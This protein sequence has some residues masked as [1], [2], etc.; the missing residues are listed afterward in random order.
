MTRIETKNMR[1]HIVALIYCFKIVRGTELGQEVLRGPQ[2][3][4]SDIIAPS[5]SYNGLNQHPPM[6]WNNWNAFGC[7]VSE[8]M[9]ISTAQTIA[10][11]GLR[12]LGYEYIMMDDC[13]S[14]GRNLTG[15]L[16]P[17]PERFPNGIRHL[18][19]RL[20]AM[21]FKF[22]M[23]SSA[24]TLTCALYAGSLGFETEDAAFFAENH[25]DYLKYDNCYNNG[26]QGTPELSFNRYDTMS[27]ALLATGRPIVYALCQW[28]TDYVWQWSQ[29]ISNSA[30]MSGDIYDS[31]NRPDPGC[32]TPDDAPSALALYKCSVMSILNTMATVQSMSRSG[33]FNDMDMLEVGNGGMDDNEYVTHFSMWAMLSSPLLIS[34]DIVS[35]S[36]ADLSILSNP[37]V[38]ALSQDPSPRAGSRIWKNE[39]QDKDQFGLCDHQLWTRTMANGD[40]VIALI[41]GGNGPATLT[42]SLNDIFTDELTSGTY[43][44][45]RQYIEQK[46]DVYDLW[47]NRMSVDDANVILN[48][49]EAST[50]KSNV[51]YNSTELPYAEGLQ[52]N[53]P[54]LLGGY[55]GEIEP[56]G[57]WAAEVARHGVGLYRLRKRGG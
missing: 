32:I 50:V 56:H 49:S 41:N 27:K 15:Y 52:I 20:H 1:L 28:G 11:Y 34:T 26:L 2:S 53:H 8:E 40:K 25:V 3:D 5:R 23:Y 12:D 14:I 48:G 6:G 10:D 42:A 22:G 39:C 30:R 19:D 44:L 37:S 46:W 43:R 16:V 18:A 38:I 33:W 51:W 17:D 9:L 47:A 55:V 13:W 57:K 7:E 35:I 54:A 31:F 24:G 4:L 29:P 36:P 21:G 45:S